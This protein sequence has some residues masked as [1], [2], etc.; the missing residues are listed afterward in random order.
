MHLGVYATVYAQSMRLYRYICSCSLECGPRSKLARVTSSL[1]GFR[2][3][4]LRNTRYRSYRFGTPKDTFGCL[5]VASSANIESYTGKLLSRALATSTVISMHRYYSPRFLENFVR[6]LEMRNKLEFFCREN[7]ARFVSTFNR[8]T[9]LNS[10]SMETIHRRQ[11]E[12]QRVDIANKKK[13]FPV[14][15]FRNVRRQ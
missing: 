15:M 1:A 10:V 12:S 5:W 9:D 6:C 4:R 11:W 8:N 13:I 3:F 2:Q 14:Q 7:S